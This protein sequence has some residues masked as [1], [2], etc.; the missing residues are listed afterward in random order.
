MDGVEYCFQIHQ[1][2][3]EFI[4]TVFRKPGDVV[5]RYRYQRSPWRVRECVF[6][7][8]TG[9]SALRIRRVSHLPSR[10]DLVDPSSSVGRITVRGFLRN[11]FEIALKNGPFWRLHCPLFTI[12]FRGTSSDGRKLLGA[13]GSSLMQWYTSIEPGSDDPRLVCALALIH[14]W[15]WNYA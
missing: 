13:A 4:G 8:P 14:N 1:S 11:R 2:S 12:R 7:D 9:Q 5:W 10:F 6:L 3:S 15:R